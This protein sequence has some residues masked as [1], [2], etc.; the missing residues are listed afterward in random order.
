M[1]YFTATDVSIDKMQEKKLLTGYRM[2]GK[3]HL[4]ARLL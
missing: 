4:L 3:A 2:D 1:I